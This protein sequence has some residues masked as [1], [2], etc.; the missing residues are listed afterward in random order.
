MP[1]AVG[2]NFVL[3]AFR[4]LSIYSLSSLPSLIK[5]YSSD[6]WWVTDKI[7][8]AVEAEGIHNA[9]VFIDV[10]YPPGVTEPNRIPYG[11]GFQFNSP[12][13]K[14]DVIYAMDLREKN[15][16]LMS[17]FPGRSYYLCK[18]HKPMSDFTLIRIEKG[19]PTCGQRFMT[20]ATFAPTSYSTQK[21]FLG[22]AIVLLT[23]MALYTFYTALSSITQDTPDAVYGV[24]FI[25]YYT[26]AQ[27]CSPETRRRSMR[28]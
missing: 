21:R 27:L 3:P 1:K 19:S 18:I 24:D 23:S 16:L 4:A 10:W 2:S 22:V 9:I 26:A 11:S 6:Y 17:A 7:H 12:D 5:K 20:M 28:K 25:A 8:K 14:D 15:G 13:L